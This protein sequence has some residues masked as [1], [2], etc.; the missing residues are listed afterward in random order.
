MKT[1]ATRLLD[2]LGISYELR[3]YE[4]DPDDLSAVKVAAQIGLPP[5]QV[6]K[7]LCAKGDCHGHVFAV[8]PGDAELD[9]KALARATGNRSVDLASVSQLQHLTGYIRG[10]VTALAAKKSFPVHLDESG[11]RHRVIAVSAGVRGTQILLAP[12][13]YVR[14]ANAKT[15]VFIRAAH[16]TPPGDRQ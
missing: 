6:F 9:L 16:P 11:L 3:D 1:N 4:V 5:A 15:G 14:A 7:T 12:S 10:G 2:T 8:I 13:D